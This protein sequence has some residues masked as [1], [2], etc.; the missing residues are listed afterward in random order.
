MNERYGI[1][2]GVLGWI[3][4]VCGCKEWVEAWWY[5]S[6]GGGIDEEGRYVAVKKESR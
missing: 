2:M 3:G 4:L 6:H 5:R 1:G